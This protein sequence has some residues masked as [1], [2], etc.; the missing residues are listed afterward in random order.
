MKKD[1]ILEETLKTFAMAARA[2]A[3]SILQINLKGEKA[4]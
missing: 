4:L 2:N 3:L 1:E